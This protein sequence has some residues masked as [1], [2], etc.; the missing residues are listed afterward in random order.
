MSK[1]TRFEIARLISARALQLSFGAPALTSVQKA[2]TSIELAS[3][4]L[5]KKMLPLSILRR[6][7]SGEIQR[8]EL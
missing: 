8:I 6:F 5:E 7:P 1:L 3:L 4:E 2:S